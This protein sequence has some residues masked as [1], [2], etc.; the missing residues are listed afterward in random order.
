[1]GH[2]IKTGLLL[3]LCAALLCALAAC[4][5]EDGGEGEVVELTNVSY[6]PTRE[7]YAAYNQLFSDYWL[8]LTGQTVEITQSHGGSGSQALQV[9]N[10]LEADVVTLAL[11]Q[12]VQAVADAGLIEDGFVQEFDNDSAPYTS[13]IVFLV[14][15]GNEKEITNWDDLLREDVEIVTPNPKTSGGARW[16]YLA[17]WYYFERQGLEEEEILANMTTLFQNVVVLDSGARAATTSFVENGQGDVLIAWENEAYLT[18]EEYPGEYEIVIP[19]V[20]ILC[21]PTVAVVDEVVDRNGTRE[22]AE[23]YLEYLYSEEAQRLVAENYYRPCN[24]EIYQEYVSQ[25]E[26]SV[27]TALSGDGAWIVDAVELVDIDY[28]GGWAEA[29]QRHFSDGGL[30]DQIFGE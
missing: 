30:F 9:A 8:D 2:H 28:F 4:G 25:S 16:N 12:D 17:A 26:G 21:Q 15:A 3:C 13:I 23:A 11:E 7:L 5:G 19:S 24:A 10:G 22:V 14:R 29:T 1:M 27:I 6:D 18:M 20:S